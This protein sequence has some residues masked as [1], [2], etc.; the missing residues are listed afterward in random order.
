MTVSCAWARQVSARALISYRLSRLQRSLHAVGVARDGE[1]AA[2]YAN[3]L[4]LC[5]TY[6]SDARS[7]S[8][9]YAAMR[10]CIWLVAQEKGVKNVTN[11]LTLTAA[12]LLVV[13]SGMAVVGAANAA[14]R[15]ITK[16]GR[17]SYNWVAPVSADAPDAHRYHGGPKSND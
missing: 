1:L 14:S 12:A 6:K 8:H 10:T 16:H 15:P 5:R 3:L 4:A 2:R 13:F 11:K 17:Q 7:V 9:S